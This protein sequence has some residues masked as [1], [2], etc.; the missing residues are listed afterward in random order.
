MAHVEQWM[1]PVPSRVREGDRVS[2]VD[3]GLH[4]IR[5]R[6]LAWTQYPPLGKCP[7]E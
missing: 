7:R 6:P 5:E 1:V 3:E 2:V 4:S